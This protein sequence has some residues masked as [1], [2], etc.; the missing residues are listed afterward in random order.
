MPNG[1]R[2]GSGLAQFNA[3]FSNPS[4]LD[5]YSLRVDHVVNSKLTLFG[6]AVILRPPVWIREGPC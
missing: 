4:S 2:L 3:S 1:P 6:A 5:A